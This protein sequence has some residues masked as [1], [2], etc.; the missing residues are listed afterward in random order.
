MEQLQR[1]YVPQFLAPGVNK[2]MVCFS[3]PQPQSSEFCH[4]CVF[5]IQEAL[6][7]I[8]LFYD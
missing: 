3:E 7:Y 5:I 8:K 1:V 4:M 6:L 2:V